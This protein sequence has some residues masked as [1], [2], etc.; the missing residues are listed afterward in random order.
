[1][2]DSGFFVL[3]I[4]FLIFTLVTLAACLETWRDRVELYDLFT[5]KK[6]E[7]RMK[8]KLRMKYLTGLPCE[9]VTSRLTQ[10]WYAPFD[11]TFEK[12]KDDPKDQ[13]YLLTIHEVPLRHCGEFRGH[14]QYKVLVTPAQEG[15][16]VWLFLSAFQRDYP[17]PP[18]VR[19][20][21][22]SDD[23]MMNI[24]AW[25]VEKLFGKLLGAVRVE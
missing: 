12:E 11:C 2:S 24:F 1:M 22:Y 9:V 5:L 16:A 23:D 21:K 3:L 10:K 15:S 4:F 8:H 20:S 13:M 14:I 18:I 6:R 19:G 17:S 25:E 7:K